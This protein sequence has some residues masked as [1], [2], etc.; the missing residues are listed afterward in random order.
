MQ[1][2]VG[3]IF[4]AGSLFLPHSP[5]WLKHVGRDAEAAAAWSSLGFSSVEAEKEIEATQR[6]EEQT[7]N[8]EKH[9]WDA[10]K[11]LMDKSVRKRTLLGCFLMASQQVWFILYVRFFQKPDNTLTGLWN[12][13]GS[14]CE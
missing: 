14:L 6:D 9:W 10:V 3:V 8:G 7:D 5:R 11:Q 12:R 13:W 1:A 4:S 2:V